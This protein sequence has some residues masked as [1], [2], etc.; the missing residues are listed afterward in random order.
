MDHSRSFILFATNEGIGVGYDSLQTL[1]SLI[2]PE[3]LL[4]TKYYESQ[5]RILALC[6][7]AENE[8]NRCNPLK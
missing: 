7:S 6:L 1:K 3:Y 5:F 4:V 8:H 2:K